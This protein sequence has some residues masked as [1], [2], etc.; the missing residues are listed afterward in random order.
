M[1]M[2]EDI[3]EL[4]CKTEITSFYVKT[5][6]NFVFMTVVISYEQWTIPPG[7]DRL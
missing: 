6:N 5:S 1:S 7:Y 3:K 2:L 4:A